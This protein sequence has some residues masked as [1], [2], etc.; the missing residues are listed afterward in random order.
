[1]NEHKELGSIPPTK[2][3]V[4]PAAS[5]DHRADSLDSQFSL[6]KTRQALQHEIPL[7]QP[8]LDLNIFSALGLDPEKLKAIGKSVNEMTG[9]PLSM[10]DLTELKPPDELYSFLPM[11]ASVT[12]HAKNDSIEA[13]YPTDEDIKALK[14]WL[15]K[16]EG[17]IGIFSPSIA[18]KFRNYLE[19]RGK[20][21]VTEI[22]DKTVQILDIVESI[23]NPKQEF[24]KEIYWAY[25]FLAKPYQDSDLEYA[26]DDKI[27]SRISQFVSTL[28]SAKSHSYYSE[29]SFW[30]HPKDFPIILKLFPSL[31]IPP[32]SVS[33]SDAGVAGAEL[34][35]GIEKFLRQKGISNIPPAPAAQK[36]DLFNIDTWMRG[37]AEVFAS[38][39]LERARRHLP[40]VL[41]NVYDTLPDDGP[42]FSRNAF[43][44]MENIASESEKGEDAKDIARKLWSKG[45][46]NI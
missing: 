43:K 19:K 14:P 6:D 46:T 3:S 31:G 38:E 1:M 12:A 10:P 4:D 30:L 34:M 45:S 35:E 42:Q 16:V 39:R 20:N 25:H 7:A 18:G 23:E 27:E 41:S 33:T 24:L 44:L 15:K 40:D 5:P 17:F 9:N 37:V 8:V 11:V 22:T 32:D 26:Q 13:K 36:F 29:R 21:A 2:E 28:K